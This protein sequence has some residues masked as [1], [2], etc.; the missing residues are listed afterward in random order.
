M[1]RRTRQ[2]DPEMPQIS[3]RFT[4]IETETYAK[5]FAELLAIWRIDAVAAK[6]TIKFVRFLLFISSHCLPYALKSTF[7]F[8]FFRRLRKQKSHHSFFFCGKISTSIEQ[9]HNEIHIVVA[10]VS[11]HAQWFTKNL[12]YWLFSQDS[13]NNS[14]SATAATKNTSTLLIFV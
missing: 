7:W 9:S 11:I 14:Q 8:I 2:W 12:R 6:K 13:Y 4:T 5:T 1:Y 10:H 3:S